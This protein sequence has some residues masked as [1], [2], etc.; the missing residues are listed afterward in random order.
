MISDSMYLH[1]YRMLGLIGLGS[2]ALG[3]FLLSRMIMDT[4]YALAIFN[5]VLVGFGLGTTFTQGVPAVY[6]RSSDRRR[7]LV[8]RRGHIHHT[9]H[10]VQRRQPG[11]GGVRRYHGQP[12]C[13]RPQRHHPAGAICYHI[14]VRDPD[15]SPALCADSSTSRDA[16]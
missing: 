3:T 9:V 12:L 7:L 4:P 8:H 6:H 13:L 11:S 16:T 15:S 2:M 5:I 10:A 1:D 14:I